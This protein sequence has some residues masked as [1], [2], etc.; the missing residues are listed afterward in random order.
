[1]LTERA[2]RYISSG[3]QR[4]LTF[5]VGRQ[6]GGFSLFGH[7][8]AETVLTA[9]GLMQLANLSE[10]YTIDERVLYRMKDFLFAHQN[11]NGSF[12]ITGRDTRRL[13]NSQ[14]LA[15]TAYI[16]W[17]LSETVPNDP[18]LTRS[19]DYLLGRLNIVDD[20]YTLALIANVLVNTQ[21]ARATEIVNRL[22][23]EIIQV[24]D[25]AY[26][27]S[28]TR[29]YFGAFGRIQ[30]LQAT[31]LASIALSTHGSHAAANDRL[32]NYI[33]SQRDTWGTWHSTQ[34]TILSLKALTRQPTQTDTEDGTITVILGNQRHTLDIV[35]GQTL[36]LYT[37][38]FTQLEAENFL[39]IEMVGVGRMTYKIVQ[40]F[41]APYDSVTLDRGFE[42]STV[43]RNELSV[44]EWVVQEIR[45]INTSGGVVDNGLVAVSIPQGFR[46]ERSSL[47]LL[48]HNGLI[49]RYE[50]RFDNSNL[51]LRD[52]EP[53]E[54]LVLTIAYRPAFPV[55]VTGGHVRA[56]DY[57]NP[58][59]EGYAL[60]MGIVVR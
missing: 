40:E 31:A 56:F 34:A 44:H 30:Y 42:I 12:Q 18:R 15:F 39:E 45:I 26:V 32:I 35:G 48:Q 28:T 25:T 37:L 49:Q 59:I 5:E 8:P 2:L 52:T 20:N 29:D 19:V 36:D 11:N 3:Y 16:A 23:N 50:M 14:Q 47:A 43:M 22:A 24:G 46:V 53:G 4:L 60:P 33:I 21:H 38:H 9:Y 13:S 10:V 1:V 7:A 58:M 57:Y 54:V 55:E 6:T 51:Y 27:T 41:F 17:A